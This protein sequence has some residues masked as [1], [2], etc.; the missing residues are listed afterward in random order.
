MKYEISS[1]EQDILEVLWTTGQW[2][3]GADFWEYFNSHNKQ[4]KRQTV[5]TYLSRMT[6]KGLLVKNGKKYMYVFTREEF[7]AKKAEEILNTLYDG[8]IKKFVSALTGAKK[9]NNDEAVKLKK[10]LDEF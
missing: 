5:N 8:S 2:T 1:N 6:D 7:E 9:I 10:Y 3:S 4:C